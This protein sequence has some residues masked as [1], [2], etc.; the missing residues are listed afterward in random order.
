MGALAPI[1]NLVGF[2]TG[3]VGTGAAAQKST[4]DVGT[5]TGLGNFLKTPATGTFFFN[6]VLFASSSQQVGIDFKAGGPYT[7]IP[8]LFGGTGFAG[9]QPRFDFFANNSNGLFGVDAA[10]SLDNLLK[11]ST[12]ATA[13]APT[14]SSGSTTATA[15]AAADKT[16]AAK[17]TTTKTDN[18]KLTDAQMKQVETK[19]KGMSAIDLFKLIMGQK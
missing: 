12:G 2:S 16:A 14:G 13:A 10:L 1:A 9:L 6:D 19:L 4:P 5:F 18:K 17:T 7:G 8:P 15:K 11:G 3:G